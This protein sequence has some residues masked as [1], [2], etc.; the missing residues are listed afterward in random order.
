MILPRPII[1]S[2]PFALVALLIGNCRDGDGQATAP[3]SQSGGTLSANPPSV[4]VTN[5]TSRNVSV[6]GGTSP[7]VIAEL[8][9][10]NLAQAM[11]VNP[12]ESV[13][14]LTITGVSVATGSTSVRIKDSSPS[15]EKEA[16]ITITKN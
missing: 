1:H 8:P 3:P 5:G 16:R 10:P 7:Y 13:A 14:T 4:A 15:P 2:I 12:N 11:F 6:S 9:N